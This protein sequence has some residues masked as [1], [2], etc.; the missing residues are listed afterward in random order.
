MSRELDNGADTKDEAGDLLQSIEVGQVGFNTSIPGPFGPRKGTTNVYH[1]NRM[2][3][4]ILCQLLR[5]HY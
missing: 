5:I 1:N 3:V 4:D 2:C